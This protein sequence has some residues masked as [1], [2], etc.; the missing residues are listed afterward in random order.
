MIK[1]IIF[2]LFLI[3]TPFIIFYLLNSLLPN[4]KNTKEIFTQ[5]FSTLLIIGLSISIILFYIN[6][7]FSA[8][9]IDKSYSPPY[10]K[11]GEIISGTI[12]E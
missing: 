10:I 8:K 9:N 4:R 7:I 11:N 1:L 6:P 3:L 12:Q 5:K 2:H